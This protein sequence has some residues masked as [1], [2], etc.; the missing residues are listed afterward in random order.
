[1]SDLTM[2][3]FLADEPVTRDQVRQ[4]ESERTTAVLKKFRSRLGAPGMAELSP[5]VTVDELLGADLPTQR[6]ALTEMK[7]RLGHAGVYAMLRADLV[8]GERSSRLAVAASR[9][10]IV[11]S[12]VRIVVPDFDATRFA[13]WF[14]ALTAT[15]DEAAMV[16]ASPDHYLL[17]GLSEGTQEV[18]ETTGGSPTATRFLVDYSRV[19]RLQIPIDPSYE[20]QIAGH[21]VLDDGLVIG[22]VRHQFRDRGDG[23]MEALLTVQF[24]GLFP[25]NMVA[26]HRWHLAS[27]FGNWITAAAQVASR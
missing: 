19:D 12:V 23:A 15:N 5:D 7:A 11:T 3:T 1:M 25:A 4:W 16:D 6:R 18:V 10:R 21:A 13:D 22:G 8:I 27:E 17:R 2:Q 14:N 20:I 26:A 24:P 9:G